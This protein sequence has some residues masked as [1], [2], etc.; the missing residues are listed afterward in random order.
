M[1]PA[2]SVSGYI[3]SHPQSKYFNVLSVGEDQLQDYAK[4]RGQS[5]DEVKKW[6]Q[7]IHQS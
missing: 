7:T 2:S 1:T 4:R 3:F 5:I 6:L